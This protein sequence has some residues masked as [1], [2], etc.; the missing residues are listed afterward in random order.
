MSGLQSAHS[1]SL[2]M[3]I[4]PALMSHAGKWQ[5]GHSFGVPNEFQ[6]VAH[7][8]SKDLAIIFL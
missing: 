6:I 3:V 8:S 7:I 2:V 4:Y 5:L 1:C